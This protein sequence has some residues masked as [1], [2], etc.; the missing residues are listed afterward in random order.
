M[1]HQIFASSNFC[2]FCGFFR[3]PQ[4]YVPTKQ[5]YRKVFS[6]KIYSTVKIIY[7]NTGLKEKMP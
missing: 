7:K 2:E 5:N 6:A 1:W 4:K 3:D